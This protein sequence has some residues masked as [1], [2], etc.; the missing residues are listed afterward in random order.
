MNLHNISFIDINGNPFE[1]ASLK[2]K[3]VLFVNTASECGYTPQFAQLE[4]LHQS[5]KNQN[6]TV[7]GIPSNDFGAQDP[8]DNKEIAT[9][10]QKNYGVTFSMMEKVKVL[11]GNQHAFFKWIADETG[12]DVKWNFE[13]FLIDEK[14]NFIERLKSDV[15]P[16]DEKVINWIAGTE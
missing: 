4:E 1:G 7:I 13:K 2:G 8:G 16:I 12:S 9:Y 10:C 15:S 6:F 11:G 3:K 5:F 14:G